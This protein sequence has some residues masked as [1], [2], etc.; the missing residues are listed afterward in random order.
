MQASSDA[1]AYLETN[2]CFLYYFK[3][4][5]RAGVALYPPLTHTLFV[6]LG[7]VAPPTSKHSGG[8]Y[9]CRQAGDVVWVSRGHKR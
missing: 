4:R 3:I 2:G 7:A 6:I 9:L 8:R 5:Q 1:C